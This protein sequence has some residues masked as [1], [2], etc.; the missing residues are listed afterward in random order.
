MLR[1]LSLDTNR[2]AISC[3]QVYDQ[4]FTNIFSI[5]ERILLVSEF[6]QTTSTRDV[7]LFNSM[8]RPMKK[9]Y[10]WSTRFSQ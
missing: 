10:V 7:G 3:W 8:T 4:V 6:C 5:G 9:D 2:T 1:K